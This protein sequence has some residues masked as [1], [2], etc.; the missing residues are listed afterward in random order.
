[1]I[2]RALKVT[3]ILKEPLKLNGRF[4]FPFLA[5]QR[6]PKCWASVF[7]KIVV[8]AALSGYESVQTKY[9]MNAYITLFTFILSTFMYTTYNKYLREA[10]NKYKYCKTEFGFLKN[11]KTSKDIFQCFSIC[12]DVDIA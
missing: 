9:C 7:H 3:C 4:F 6:V 12:F 10:Y 5:R 2:I 8:F 1:M 11:I